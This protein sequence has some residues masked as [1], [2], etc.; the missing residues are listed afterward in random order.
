MRGRTT[1]NKAEAKIRRGGGGGEAENRRAYHKERNPDADFVVE[2]F[3]E[4]L[5]AHEA[6]HESHGRL[7][8]RQV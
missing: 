8:E 6:E 1:H 4:H 7:E 2:E 3:R 5:G